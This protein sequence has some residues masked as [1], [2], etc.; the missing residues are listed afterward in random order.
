MISLK[1]RISRVLGSYLQGFLVGAS[2]TFPFDS[3]FQTNMIKALWVGLIACAYQVKKLCEEYGK[4][5]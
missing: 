4:K 3:D 1:Q 2:I 5:G